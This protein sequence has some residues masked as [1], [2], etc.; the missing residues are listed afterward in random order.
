MKYLGDERLEVL[1]FHGEIGRWQ[2]LFNA[3]PP[4]GAPALIS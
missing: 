4:G 3:E 1:D 2:D